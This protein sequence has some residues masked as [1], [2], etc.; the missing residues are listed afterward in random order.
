LKCVGHVAVGIDAPTQPRDRFRVSTDLR[1]GDTD[2]HHPSEGADVA[3]REAERL[4]DM[5]FGFRAATEKKLGSTDASVSVGQILVQRQR[6]LAFDDAFGRTVCSNVDDAQSE[7]GQGKVRGNRQSLGRS[8]FP[9]GKS[10]SPVVGEKTG[11][12]SYIN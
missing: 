6:L 12:N 8:C 11:P 7:V 3:G 4:V 9:R 2:Q 10:R 5:A 1:F